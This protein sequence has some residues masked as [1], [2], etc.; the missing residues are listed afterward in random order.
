MT[1]SFV[2]AFDWEKQTRRS[3]YLS[4]WKQYIALKFLRAQRE[5]QCVGT[6]PPFS[7][8]VAVSLSN[9][10]S[11]TVKLHIS[12]A[13]APLAYI[14]LSSV[15][16]RNPILLLAS[17]MLSNSFTSFKENAVLVGWLCFFAGILLMPLRKQ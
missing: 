6:Y 2:R 15:L 3:V 10:T 11:A 7:V 12:C 17:G 1:R 9:L 4:L 5:S 16:S 13:L 8:S 14:T